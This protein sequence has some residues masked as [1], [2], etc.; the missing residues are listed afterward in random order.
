M[1]RLLIPVLLVSLLALT[2][3][4]IEEGDPP[5]LQC[6]DGCC[7]NEGQ[8]LIGH[9]SDACGTGTGAS[10]QNIAGACRCALL[11]IDTPPEPLPNDGD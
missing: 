5:I 1:I 6:F 11:D 10:C 9:E 2:G 8:C 4:P 7:D 3:C